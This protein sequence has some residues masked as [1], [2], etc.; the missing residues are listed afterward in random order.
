MQGLRDLF[1]LWEQFVSN[2]SSA[3]QFRKEP[4]EPKD[5]DLCCESGIDFKYSFNIQECLF[6][7]EDES[8][9]SADVQ[10]RGKERKKKRVGPNG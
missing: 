5:L 10:G 2:E 6:L 9:P 8:I 7:Q 4:N 3:F 1:Y